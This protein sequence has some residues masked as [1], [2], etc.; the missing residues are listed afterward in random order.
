MKVKVRTEKKDLCY[1]QVNNFEKTSGEIT[2]NVV[3]NNNNISKNLVK[4]S[5]VIIETGQFSN[6]VE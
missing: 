1:F 6:I 2:M 5:V 4:L 3:Q